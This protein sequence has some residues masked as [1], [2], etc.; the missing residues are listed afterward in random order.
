MFDHVEAS[1][2]MNYCH[3]VPESHSLSYKV[4]VLTQFLLLEL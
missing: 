3:S 2:E 1:L 4:S